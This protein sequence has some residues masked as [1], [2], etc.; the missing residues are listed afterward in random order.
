MGEGAPAAGYRT[1]THPVFDF[2]AGCVSF[3]VFSIGVNS[4]FQRG[5]LFMFSYPQ[6]CATFS[7][8]FRILSERCAVLLSQAKMK[9]RIHVTFPSSRI[10]ENPFLVFLQYNI[11]TIKIYPS[12]ASSHGASW[13]DILLSRTL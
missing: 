10:K 8:S 11:S 12:S 7:S 4:Y 2:P 9:P 6:P 3:H 1:K 13:V 5:F